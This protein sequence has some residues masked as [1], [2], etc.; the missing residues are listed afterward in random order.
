M[1]MADA[2]AGAATTTT[3]TNG[4]ASELGTITPSEY[5]VSYTIEEETFGTFV[6]V[7][8][9]DTYRTISSNG[10]PP[11]DTSENFPNPDNE[12]TVEEQDLFFEIPLTTNYLGTPSIV[13]EV[14][15]SVFGVMYEPGNAQKASC[16]DGTELQIEVCANNPIPVLSSLLC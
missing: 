12:Y 7:V 2:P 8:V 1:M 14:G 4:T 6:D 5:Y 9:N 16:D 15:I 13:R 11:W 3:S 10:I